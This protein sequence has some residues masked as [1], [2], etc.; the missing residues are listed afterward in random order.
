MRHRSLWTIKRN[1]YR[2]LILY[3]VLIVWWFVWEYLY[4]MYDTRPD[5]VFSPHAVTVA[6]IG[7]Q[8]DDIS[9]TVS[10]RASGVIISPD[11]L[12][13]TAKHVLASGAIYD[14]IT[15]D[16]IHY[17]V[18]E[19]WYDPHRDLAVLQIRDTSWLKPR[20]LPFV[21]LPSKSSIATGYIT[22]LGYRDET[23]LVSLTGM[24]VWY[25]DGIYEI[26]SHLSPWMSGW[27]LMTSDGRL[28]GINISVS[29]RSIDQSFALAVDQEIVQW[30]LG[31]NTPL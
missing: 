20:K 17:S 24:V 6:L 7:S 10:S 27:P 14:I 12:I 11:G 28:W 25:R 29:T 15:H 8:S 26:T 2:V 5:D 16:Q 22:T 1:A 19:I 13:L 31:K 4:P 23:K 9:H 21:A 3:I 18:S 30:F